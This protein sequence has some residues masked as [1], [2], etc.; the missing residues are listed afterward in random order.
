MDKGNWK[1]YFAFSK[2]QRR[3]VIVLSSIIVLLIA[4]PYLFSPEF[5]KPFVNQ[6]L[7][8]QLLAMQKGEY[9]KEHQPS[10]IDQPPQDEPF[11]NVSSGSTGLHPFGFDPNKLDEA[12][13]TQMGLSNAVIQNIMRY[14][15]QGG[16]FNE[17]NDFRKINGLQKKEADILV[18][19]INIESTKQETQVEKAVPVNEEPVEVAKPVFK[20]LDI[21][22]ATAEELEALPGIGDVL[23][24][25]IVK[26][27][28]AVNGFKSLEDIKKTYGLSD[29][30]YQVILPYLTIS[31]IAP[32]KH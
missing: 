26:F 4:L 32:E 15:N 11:A 24:K 31:D 17:A 12:G 29:S 22:T 23:S 14:R 13:F 25:R 18:P 2:M 30:V 20:K 3:G 19:Y 9:E 8:Q 1:D 6:E 21:N 10:A 27:R 7:Q 28:N 5:K 16:H